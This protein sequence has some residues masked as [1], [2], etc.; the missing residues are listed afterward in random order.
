MLQQYLYMSRRT[1]RRRVSLQF[2]GVKKIDRRRGTACES[3]ILGDIKEVD[4]KRFHH[5]VPSECSVSFDK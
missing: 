4:R 5:D 1:S 3:A 2:L